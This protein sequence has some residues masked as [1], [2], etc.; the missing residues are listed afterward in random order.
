[1]TALRIHFLEYLDNRQIAPLAANEHLNS[2]VQQTRAP[3]LYLILLGL[4][5]TLR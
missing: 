5:F 1:M 4:L 2:Q 3:I